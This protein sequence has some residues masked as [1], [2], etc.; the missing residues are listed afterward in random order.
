MLLSACASSSAPKRGDFGEATQPWM[1][2]ESDLSTRRLFRVSYSGHEGSGSLRV[3]MIL[4]SGPLFSLMASDPLGRSLWDLQIDRDQSFFVNHRE[5]KICPIDSLMVLPG[6]TLEMFPLESLPLVLLGYLPATPQ[7]GQISSDE[8]LSFLDDQGRRWTAALK[9]R[10]VS[11]WTLWMGEEPL[12]WWTR[13]AKGGI[14]SHRRGSQF[15][16]KEVVVEALDGPY[17]GVE[18]QSSYQRVVCSESDL[19][20]L[21]EDQP[22]P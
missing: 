3:V 8:E 17:G 18:P 5:S 22:P 12:L 6:D 16:W 7:T 20:E 2:S 4:A 10:Q 19:P 21:R 15:R 1:L 13:Q 14:L 11:S 9:D